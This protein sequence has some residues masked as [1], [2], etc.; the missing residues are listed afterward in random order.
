M[1]Y[2]TKKQVKSVVSVLQ[3]S[4]ELVSLLTDKNDLTGILIEM[5]NLAI[6]I[7]EQ[8]E[9]ERGTEDIVT[10]LEEFC[11][12][13]Y[14]IYA[15]I[16]DEKGYIE[17][18]N[19]A[20]QELSKIWAMSIKCEIEYKV[21]FL[22]YK[23]SMWDS[24]ESIF[25][26]A[27]KQENVI[28]N[29]VPIPYFNKNEKNEKIEMIY[30]G[31][32][33][34]ERYDIQDYREY[35]IEQERPDIIFIH[36]PYDNWNRITEV[37]EEYFSY[38]LKKTGAILVY[39]PYYTAGYCEKLENMSTCRTTGAFN[40]DYIIL[41]SENLK[42]AFL[43]WGIEEKKLLVTGSPKIDYVQNVINQTDHNSG[44]WN[45]VLHDRVV[46]FLN[47][48]LH[49]FLNNKNWIEQ[50]ETVIRAITSRET[51]G[52]IWRPHPLFRSTLVSMRPGE[53]ERWEALFHT[54]ENEKGIIL[55]YKNDYK[56]AF[57]YSDAMISDYSSL[58]LLYTYTGK[59]VYLLRGTQKNR[60][61]I[62]FC[63]YFSNYFR[64]DGMRLED[65]MDN[66][67]NKIDPKKEERMRYACSS[68]ANTDGTCGEKTW[69]EILKKM[70]NQLY[71]DDF[72]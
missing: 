69:N 39:V 36:N 30:E 18:I 50:I 72:N 26:T 45:D 70:E 51:C 29:L 61:K 19:A 1:K 63:D 49:T 28:C 48:G 8:V 56:N 54:A 58:V 11:E 52:L 64:E 35:Q 24:M 59:P 7:G 41:Q 22:P 15:A 2:L 23:I 38:N 5:Q 10:C 4:M 42:K 9:K 55:D 67:C 32:A 37:K 43:F 40:A 44:K 16:E 68:V 27:K 65:Y 3:K 12:E 31:E 53:K 66:V 46:F 33:F 6:Q 57:V 17:Y 71:A 25:L 14:C 34:R 60:E 62:V 21:L 13:I 20:K 47:T